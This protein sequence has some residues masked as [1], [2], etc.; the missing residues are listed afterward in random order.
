MEKGPR[1]LKLEFL[2]YLRA[3]LLRGREVGSLLMHASIPILHVSFFLSD[4][5]IFPFFFF[6]LLCFLFFLSTPIFCRCFSS[7]FFPP[8]SLFM[9]M[10]FYTVCRDKIYHFYP[11]TAF[12]LLWASFQ[13]CPLVCWMLN[14]YHYTLLAAPCLIPRQKKVFVLS[15][16]SLYFQYSHPDKG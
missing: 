16:T 10:A 1:W 2:A 8:F 12:G 13:D 7:H 14:H 15:F 5:C 11:S 3:G 9:P 6:F 4:F